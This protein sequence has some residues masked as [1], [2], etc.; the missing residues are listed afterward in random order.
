MEAVVRNEGQECSEV[1]VHFVDKESIGQLHAEY[2]SDPSPT[3]C[4]SFPLDGP[5]VEE[6]RVLGEVFVC[7]Q[8]AAEY[9]AVHCGC[10]ERETILYIVHGLLHCLGYDDIED[11]DR[12]EM[13][14]AEARHLDALCADGLCPAG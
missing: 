10:V 14:A 12:A 5:E 2:F 1:S 9:C 3:D 11:A 8:V 13:R 4:I 7:P 6:Q